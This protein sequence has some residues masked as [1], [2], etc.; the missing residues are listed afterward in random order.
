MDYMTKPLSR[1]AN[2]SKAGTHVVPA[3]PKGEA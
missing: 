3:H 2:Y 1:I